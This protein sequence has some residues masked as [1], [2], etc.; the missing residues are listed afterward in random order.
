MGWVGVACL[1][2]AT[3][4]AGTAA[5]EGLARVSCRDSGRVVYLANVAES[6]VPAATAAALAEFP[7]ALCVSLG[8]EPPPEAPVPGAPGDIASVLSGATAAP[9]QT[10]GAS[11][12]DAAIRAL[13]GDAIHVA[14]PTPVPATP[15]VGE[16]VVV[17]ALNFDAMQPPRADWARLGVY[18]GA[19]AD[20]ALAD[21][22]R[23]TSADPATFASLTPD[24]RVVDGAAML[25]AGPVPPGGR[26]SFCLAAEALSLD[27][28]F[29]APPPAP[30]AEEALAMAGMGTDPGS[31]PRVDALDAEADVA[32]PGA[33]VGHLACWVSPYALDEADALPVGDLAVHPV[34]APAVTA[35]ALRPPG[36]AQ[37]RRHGHGVAG[38]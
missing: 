27:C 4:W 29:G 30:E 26:E 14:V 23:I 20:V 25:G 5:A 13:R 24:I 2:A 38:R 12:L 3:A 6:A 19:D 17:R 32:S 36:R 11:G 18:K 16:G 31:C 7:G 28:R 15:P 8:P 10:T 34:P 35:A 9:P 21:W 37:A 1:A 33:A 22:D